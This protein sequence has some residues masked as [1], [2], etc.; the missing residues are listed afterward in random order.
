MNLAH[1]FET[2]PTIQAYDFSKFQTIA[3]V[4][5]G[6]GQLL[7]AILKKHRSLKGILFDQPNVLEDAEPILSAAGVADRVKCVG[8]SFMTSVPTGADAYILR[9][10]IHDWDDATSNRI[11]RNV[12][13]AIPGNGLV[14]L[15]E[16]VIPPGNDYFVGK[17][18]DL[19]M[20]LIGGKERTKEEYTVLLAKSGFKLTRVVPTTTE[21]S[22][23]EG[24]AA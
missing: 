14:L 23:I 22:V 21:L 11:L 12:R 10:I 8:G 16:A 19:T 15:M 20:L 13:A 4:G 17:F 7:A 18:L 9:N 1:G 24:S 5:G 2:E 3:D 6:N